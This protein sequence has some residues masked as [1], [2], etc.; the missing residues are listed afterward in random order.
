MERDTLI[1]NVLTIA[2][3]DPTGGA[4]IQADLKAFSAN[5]AYGMSVVTAVVSQNTCGVRSIVALEPEFVASQIAAVFDDVRVDAIKIGMVA[6]AS[7]AQAIAQTLGKY[8]PCPVV[9]DPVMVAKSGDHLLKPE[10]VAAIRHALIPRAT[11]ITPNLPEASVLLDREEEIASLSQMRN[12]VPHLLSLGASW[13][14]LKGGH[15]PGE[16]STD[17][18]A[19]SNSGV[20]LLG[21]QDSQEATGSG[22]LKTI[23]LS[24][25]RVKTLN[26]H[27]TGCTL[28]A[29]IAALLPRY[30]YV[31]SVR[32]AKEYL[33]G[34]LIHANELEVGSGHGP[35]HHFYAL[36]EGSQGE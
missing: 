18:L 27:G 25:P 15:L 2:G 12:A 36:W 30:G 28:S 1:P 5:G 4:G 35:V 23:E 24:V 16:T 10:A 33:T 20:E 9:L 31:E 14:L 11:L 32:R 13:V 8:P 22:A 29:A 19:R 6:N 7:I 34:A 17:I 21:V 3:T 26:D